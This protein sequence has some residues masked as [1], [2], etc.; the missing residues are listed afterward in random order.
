MP[1]AE[2]R[3][4][5]KRTPAPAR[6]APPLRARIE[7][8]LAGAAAGAELG[9]SRLAHPEGFKLGQAYD[10][11]RVRLDPPGRYREERH[12]AT[13][14]SL[15]PF[16]DVGV[17]A[18]L[19][20]GGRATP[21]DFAAVFA[22]HRG[23]AAPAFAL[24]GAHNVQEL[25]A[26]G[27]H[28]RLCG[29]GNA[30]CGFFAAAM[31]ATG[32]YHFADPEH[33]YLDGVE[34]ASVGQPRL[35]ADWAALCAAAVAAAFAPGASP[36]SVVKTA[37][38][39]AHANNPDLYYAIN[40]PVREL[41]RRLKDGGDSA[42][43]WWF[44]RGAKAG[45]DRLRNWTAY[46]PV[47]FVLPP[48]LAC[49]ADG[50]LFFKWVLAAQPEGFTAW[51]GGGH[52]PSAVVGG[53]VLGALYGREAFSANLW[54]WARPLAEPW[55]EL[56]NVVDARVKTEARIVVELERARTGSARGGPGL[57][58]KIHGNILAGAIGNAMGSPVEGKLFNE[59]D[60]EHP[61]GIRTVLDPSRLESED[62]N[63]MAMLL[64]ETYIE[65]GGAPVMARH[66]GRT[67]RERLDRDHFFPLC[68]GNAYDMLRAGWDPRIAG[69]WSVVTGSTVMCMEPVGMY[70]AADPEFAVIDATAVSYMYQRGLDVSAAANMAAAVAEALRPGANVD[71]VCRAALEAAP[72]ERLRTFDR[73]PFKSFREYLDA[74]L[75]VADKY[76][77]VLAARAELYEKCLL[78]HH[79]DPLELWGFSLAIFKI[80]DGDVRQCAIGGTNI[81]RDSDTIAGRAAMLAGT[82]RG[83]DAVP[84]EW[85]ALF[86]PEAL[87][88]IR[89]NAYRFADLVAGPKTAILR[90][91][92]RAAGR[93]RNRG[94]RR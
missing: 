74:C 49:G 40:G 79:I 14:A 43:A 63:Q 84:A 37:L 64:S 88:K 86:K 51:L 17:Q 52:I 34:L 18:C 87:R 90:D 82:L 62:D 26:E 30:P 80:A 60:A 76:T 70:N 39:L 24:D 7:A 9:L 6:Q 32:I 15:Q 83:A 56:C 20:R 75:T 72:R 35:G 27:M 65:R 25:L 89:R 10:L 69:H 71:S 53:A 58:E 77:D 42:A 8:A 38:K 94:R 31:P 57:R 47:E 46:N 78:Y 44:E 73:R 59:I 54:R 91:R 2:K 55:M 19:R 23:I 68:M 41:R 3:S 48:L 33:A 21:E 22:K 29:L 4:A 16:I 61:G 1:A 67:W 81:G 36:E 13:H 93:Q 92:Q 11:S 5:K 12:R 50:D 66:F 45:A 85:T 28:P